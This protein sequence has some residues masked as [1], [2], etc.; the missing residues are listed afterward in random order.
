MKKII[1]LILACMMLFSLCSCQLL[2]EFF[3]QFGE[4]VDP[5][6]K[7]DTPPVE[8]DTTRE[9]VNVIIMAG[10][11]NA[12]GNTNMSNLEA[13]CKD[14]GKDYSRYVNG[15]EEVKVS[16][17]YH[18]YYADLGVYSTN[19][20]DPFKTNFVDV[21]V[22]QGKS[23]T[24][25]GPELGMAEVISESIDASQPV[26]IIKYCS[27]GTAFSGTPSWK[28]PSSGTTGELYSNFIKYVNAGLEDLIEQGF[29]PKIRAFVWM[30]GESDSDKGSATAYK[31][32]MK[33][34]VNDIRDTYSY[35][36]TDGVGDNIIV[37]DGQ[38]AAAA[39]WP[40]HKI[41]NQAK[42][43][44][45]NEMENYYAIDTNG[46]NLKLSSGDKYGGGDAY[47]YSMES[48][49][50]LGRAFGETIVESGCLEYTEGKVETVKD[51]SVD[52][53]S[54]NNVVRIE[55]ENGNIKTESGLQV[56]SATTASGGK[57]IG[58]FWDNN[59]P[60]IR[61]VVESDKEEKN[62]VLSLALASSVAQSVTELPHPLYKTKLIS[63]NGEP[64]ALSGTLSARNGAS[65]YNFDVHSTYID[66]KA[67]TNII[68]IHYDYNCSYS[69]E[70][71]RLNLDYFEI[72][73]ES[74]KVTELNCDTIGSDKC[75]A[76]G[77]NITT[78]THSPSPDNYAVTELNKAGAII[79]GEFTADATSKAAF[80][81]I[82]GLK[83]EAKLSE[84][85][86]LS[87]NGVAV[88]IDDVLLNE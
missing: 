52:V 39:V 37:V 35:Y 57:C 4:Q 66:L 28:S 78:V 58:F 51:F 45:G 76:V 25:S 62:A 54:R 33:N 3:A 68:D 19:K 12:E 36:A 49:L 20:D 18:Y 56:E 77:T 85:F 47:H 32:Y 24:Y 6:D 2:D 80:G 60:L 30:Q 23:P 34:M 14:K 13:Y 69:M 59:N 44:L 43:D 64:V 81:I 5:D 48:I 74:A 67:G 29:S 22:G 31:G 50:K 42:I 55:V 40:D 82:F 72:I 8:D 87:I 16:F 70:E 88:A 75:T 71:F 9:E 53:G 86:D 83:S 46:L 63:V 10:Q 65:Y 1:A 15:F 21:K 11:S 7:P 27:G 41:I 79:K 38:I 84:Y 73:T 17:H 61:F 26:Y